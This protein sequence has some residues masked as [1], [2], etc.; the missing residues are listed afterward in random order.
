MISNA[1]MPTPPPM[2]PLEKVLKGLPAAPG[3]AIGLVH[4]HLNRLDRIPVYRV[5]STD[6]DSEVKRF[7]EAVERSLHQLQKLQVRAQH[8]PASASD[9]LDYLL[10]AHINILTSRR[11]TDVVRARILNL[12]INAEAAVESGVG[13]LLG[14]QGGEQALARQAEE[15][16]DV[17]GRLVRNL[18][19][20]PFSSLK[21]MP[22][23]CVIAAD[24]LTPADTVYMQPGTVAGICMASGGVDSHT[25]I[26]ARTLQIPAVVGVADLLGQL[27][28]G[29]TL[30]VDGIDGCVVINPTADT[31]AEMQAKAKDY[32]EAKAH[33]VQQAQLPAATRDGAVVEVMVNLEMPRDYQSVAKHGAGGIGLVRTEF[34]FMHHT[35]PPTVDQQLEFFAQLAHVVEGQPIVVRTFDVGADKRPLF[36]DEES[37]A[38]DNPAL[39]LRGIRWQ[40]RRPEILDAQLSAFLRARALGDFRLM[41]PMVTQV[42]EVTAVRARLAQL[43][44]QLKANYPQLPSS[45]PLLGIMVETPAAALMAE[46]LTQ[47]VD[48]ISIG[49]NDLTMYTLAADRNDQAVSG[50]YDALSPAV[51]QLIAQT[52]SAG[53]RRGVPVSICGEL[54]SD[55]RYTA[56]LLGLGM[57]QLSVASVALA[58]VKSMV[59]KLSIRAAQSLADQVL[60]AASAQQA[61]RLVDQFNAGLIED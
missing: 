14:G 49:T 3:I 30:I 12:K 28:L 26:L 34:L 10:D 53:Q 46:A 47:V 25:A 23:G 18:I 21:T 17:A 19:Q 27:S 16:R 15:I 35:T 43:Q 6:I 33:Q 11:L 5:R 52:I 51:C 42:D 50:V 22:T 7:E 37:L 40:L 20:Q 57:R 44:Q 55:P 31:Q 1:F 60:Q 13:E 45:A 9:E 29:D 32:A 38:C 4:I 54:A 2:G 56:L 58:P 8:L 59:R 36:V 41:L 61:H 39:G 24:E 48:F